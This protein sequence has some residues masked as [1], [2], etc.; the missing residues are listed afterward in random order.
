MT[1][2]RD[3]LSTAA[4]ALADGN[5][6]AVVDAGSRDV[7][8]AAVAAMQSAMRA[9]AARRRRRAWIGRLSVAAAVVLGVVG[10]ARVWSAW[11]ARS[12]TTTPPA[13]VAVTVD[14][15]GKGLAT[16]FHD[17][18]AVPFDGAKLSRGD[19][20]VTASDAHAQI[21]LSTGTELALAPAA[22]VTLAQMSTLQEVDLGAGAVHA[23][24]AKLK[25]GDRFLVRTRDAEVEVRGTTFE[26]AVVTPDPSCG[27]GTP[28]RVT[29][30]EGVVVVRANGTEMHLAA[31]EQ[32]PAG[33]ASPTAI[34]NA[35]TLAPS[36][37]PTLALAPAIEIEP[38]P[39]TS[40]SSTTTSASASVGPD[41]LA[42]KNDLFASALAA[43]RKGDLAS[44]LSGFEAYLA[45]YPGGELAESASAQKMDILSKIDPTRAVS[46]AH[47]YLARY[48]NG[49]AR[50]Q[51]ESILSANGGATP[52]P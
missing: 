51:A 46:A 10:G 3:L 8:A 12:H 52:T 11:H 4:K 48:P 20:I 50:E 9:R 2:G 5:D 31:G 36:P 38:A 35:P 18:H 13:P 49:F 19:R 28:T 16:A 32:W 47:E 25:D 14:A 27:K 33:C 34:A 40:P 21:L 22:D 26:V 1:R 44:A 43:K 15:T 29:V 45:Q 23:H 41:G 24:V 17:G 30:T 37:A 6:E 39:K 42:A 7:R